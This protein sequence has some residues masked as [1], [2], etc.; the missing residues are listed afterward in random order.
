MG[1]ALSEFVSPVPTLPP[2]NKEETVQVRFE[3]GQSVALT[4][5]RRGT[6]I[7]VLAHKY[8]GSAA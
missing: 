6:T 4:F 2:D 7:A 3:G 5:S 1:R 8:G